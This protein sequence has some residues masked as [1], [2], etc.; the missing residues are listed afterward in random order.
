MLSKYFRELS[1]NKLTG[2]IF[3]IIV[4]LIAQILFSK[5]GF[6]PTDDGFI[7]AGAR[8][9]L[10]GQIPHLDFISIRPALS[11]YLYAPL[12]Y[13]GGDY[14]VWISRYFVWFQF[15]CI[16]WAWVLI[17]NYVFKSFESP[18]KKITIALIAFFFS[19]HYF[20]VMVW[21]TLDALFFSSLGILLLIK[22]SK[23]N[24]PKFF[25]YLLLGLTPLFRQNFVF[26][27]PVTLFIL[28]DWKK[29][30]YLIAAIIPIISYILYLASNNALKDAIIQLSSYSSTTIIQTG[31]INYLDSSFIIGLTVGFFVILI[32]SYK[33]SP[34]TGNINYYKFIS[35][36]TVFGMLII[37]ALSIAF[38]N[39]TFTDYSSY[40]IIGLV[41]G[42]IMALSYKERKITP[43]TILGIL[44]LIMAWCTSLSIG[45]DNPAIAT[46]PLV[47]Y[48]ICSLICMSCRY[49]KK[50]DLKF[51]NFNSFYTRYITLL[52]IFL[53]IISGFSFGWAR[54]THIYREDPAYCLNYS[55]DNISGMKFVNTN[56]NNYLMLND[57]N[58]AQTL[59]KEKGK[60]YAIIPDCAFIW[61]TS[62]QLD[63]LIIDWPQDVELNNPQ[64][65]NRLIDDINSQKEDIIFIVSKYESSEVYEGFKPL[66]YYKLVNYVH[67]NFRQIDETKYYE[68]YEYS[69]K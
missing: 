48:I 59:V 66:R 24:L 40:V 3:I 2:I 31:L 7:L 67:K 20:P 19:A 27:I 11:Y 34:K 9:I 5:L 44:V 29:L 10:E 16:S 22:P 26:I 69:N 42:F 43:Y 51:N 37:T 61:I 21:H 1:L 50:Y 49:L 41:L 30:K 32:L 35:I 36:T 64:V 60:K 33:F 46:G 23:S 8:R 12:V 39:A 63:P 52:L 38:P 65:Y 14:V 18:F 58:K 45:Y 56:L 28:N 53:L 4:P 57:L 17:A 54:E 6:N 15:A 13:F 68:L 47:I 55:L 62:S 25:G